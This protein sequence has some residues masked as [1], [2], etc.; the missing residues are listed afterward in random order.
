MEN[1]EILSPV[2]HQIEPEQKDFFMLVMLNS[3]VLNHPLPW[4]PEQ[5]WS[6]EI[7]D[8]KDKLV[9]K[10]P[11][12]EATLQFIDLVSKF[13]A[14]RDTLEAQLLKDLDIDLDIPQ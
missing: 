1:N 12:R 6:A 7:Y 11:K 5:D 13:A 9:I 10:F 14:E 2:I 8:A 3:L 4:R